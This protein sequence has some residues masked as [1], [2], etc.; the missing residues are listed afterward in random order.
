MPV[1]QV[2][3]RGG[4]PVRIFTDDVDRQSIEQLVAVSRLPVVVG[5]VAAM[6][7][8]HVGIGATIGSVIPTRRA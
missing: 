8:V 6:P 5:H 7:D 2:I 3:D 1:R 4:V